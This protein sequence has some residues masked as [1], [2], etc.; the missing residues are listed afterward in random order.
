MFFIF[1]LI[2]FAALFDDMTLKVFGKSKRKKALFLGCA[3]LIA[4]ILS[5][6]I[7]ILIII[8]YVVIE[9]KE[10]VVLAHVKAENRHDVDAS[11]ATSLVPRYQVVPKE[12]YTMVNK[13]I[14]YGGNYQDLSF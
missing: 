1:V 8:K 14:I 9:R 6:C 12:W 5:K 13:I 11:I 10:S 3:T 4:A 7:R 2:S